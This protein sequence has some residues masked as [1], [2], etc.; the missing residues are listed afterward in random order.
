MISTEL[1]N[2]TEAK[3]LHLVNLWNIAETV[4]QIYDAL[5]VSN[6]HELAD[7]IQQ[8]TTFTDWQYFI[9]DN[10]VQ[11]YIDRV[12]YAQAGVVI[13]KMMQDGVHLTQAESAKLNAA[14]KYRDDH[15]PNFATPV[16]Y[17]Y[18]QTPLTPDEQ[19]FLPDVPENKV[20]E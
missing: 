11:D 8:G 15:R 14:I 19:A 20:D 6:P 5:F 9:N 13:N 18:I 2:K 7:I 12:I 1:F 17:I 4:P 16:Q 3:M 10:R